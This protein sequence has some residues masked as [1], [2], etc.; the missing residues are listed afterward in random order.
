MPS[1]GLLPCRAAISMP[2]STCLPFGV[3]IAY[4]VSRTMKSRPSPSS[5]FAILRSSAVSQV[6]F[7]T[8]ASL[9]KSFRSLS[10]SAVNLRLGVRAG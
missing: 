3:M 7:P 10:V 6:A 5:G 1:P 8:A 4:S 9:S 2:A